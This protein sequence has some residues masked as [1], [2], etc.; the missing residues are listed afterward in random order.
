M[1]GDGE[2]AARSVLSVPRVTSSYVTWGPVG[3]RGAGYA[4]RA[5]IP[6]DY[7]VLIISQEVHIIH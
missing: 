4:W 6:G 5:V 7:L 3:S 2:L 1:S